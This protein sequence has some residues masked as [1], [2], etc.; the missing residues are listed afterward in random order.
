[1]ASWLRAEIVLGQEVVGVGACGSGQ[2]R[3][4]GRAWREFKFRVLGSWK[5]ENDVVDDNAKDQV[6]CGASVASARWEVRA[7]SW[8]QLRV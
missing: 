4:V 3:V 8:A 7:L 6:L 1:M 5:R 2:V